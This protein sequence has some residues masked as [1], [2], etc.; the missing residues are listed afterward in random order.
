MRACRLVAIITAI[1]FVVT[2]LKASASEFYYAANN[3]KNKVSIIDPAQI[4]ELS[5]NHKTFHVAYIGEFDLWTDSTYEIDCSAMRIRTISVMN[6]L[7]EGDPMDLTQYNDTVTWHDITVDSIGDSYKNIVCPFPQVK[8]ERKNIVEYKDFNSAVKAESGFF[9]CLSDDPEISMHGCT[10]Y[11]QSGHQ[12][13]KL[14]ASVYNQ[15]GIHY[16]G[17]DDLDHAIQDFDEALLIDT[18][19]SDYLAWRGFSYIQKGDYDRAMHDLNEA[20][21]FKPDSSFAL[22]NRGDIF[23][24]QGD[25]MSAIHDFN[26]AIRLQPDY[27]VALNN[28][29][30]SRAIVGQLAAALEDCNQALKIEPNNSSALGNRAFVYLKMKMPDAAIA[31]FNAALKIDP[32]TPTYIYGRGLAKCMTGESSAC[33]SDMQT[34][35]FLQP[36]IDKFYAKSGFSDSLPTAQPVTQPSTY[37]RDDHWKFC[38]GGDANTDQQIT[39]CSVIINSGQENN[40][41]LAAALNNRGNAY[42]GKRL[43]DKAFQDYKKSIDLNPDALAYY[44]LGTLYLFQKSDYL[45]AIE[46]YSAAIR[47]KPDYI[48]AI[49]NRGVAYDN[50]G[51]SNH[52]I[53][54][55]TEVIRLK[56][57]YLYAYFNRANDYQDKGDYQQAIQDYTSAINLKPDYQQALENRGFV[58]LKMKNYDGAIADYTAALAI[59]PKLATSLYGRGL[60]E[61]ANGN[62]AAAN[63][64]IA[65]AKAIKPSIAADF[66][67]WG[68]PSNKP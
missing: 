1:L 25:D 34:A 45:H 4:V 33:K 49:N 58:Y 11:I 52:A 22:N 5:N 6:H 2:G 35:L 27:M 15:R 37:V 62:L 54:D 40:A 13:D 23:H 59:N 12:R 55:Y 51:D 60:A 38:V 39:E 26:E 9:D 57:D 43:F 10:D 16:L 31:D 50:K 30:F 19:N 63:K 36:N 7:S 66:A 44:N 32:Q 48:E 47:L 42:E 29:C 41:S 14:L 28:R 68:I 3:D 64:D 21:Q 17:K 53:A 65:A 8:P 24:H 46:T 18:T 20:I 56:P 61:R 67:K